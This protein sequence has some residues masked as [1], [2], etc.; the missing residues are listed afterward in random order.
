[1]PS[2]R[3][4]SVA[5]RT[6]G[7]PTCFFV[8]DSRCGARITAPVWPLQP[9]TSRPESFSGRNGS[10]ALPKIDSTKS[11][12]LTKPPGTKK[13]V[14]MRRAG[15]KPGIPGATSGRSKSDTNP[16]AV[17]SKGKASAVSGGSRAIRR[18]AANV[19]CGTVFLSAGIGR[20][21]S[22]TWKVPLVVRRSLRG[23]CST[24]LATR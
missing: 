18:R 2:R 1:M 16:L 6:W 14:S 12:L 9:S 15:E 17:A 24:P 4:R 22:A 13:R 19:R 10:P 20:P 3:W 23:L 5:F 8:T 21:P 7:R 11:R